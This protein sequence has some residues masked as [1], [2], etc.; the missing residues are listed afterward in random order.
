LQLRAK[1]FGA[2]SWVRL[3][4]FSQMSHP[5]ENRPPKSRIGPQ[6]PLRRSAEAGRS[7]TFRDLSPKRR[8]SIHL[9][10]NRHHSARSACA[11]DARVRVEF[12]QNHRI[13]SEKRAKKIFAETDF[14]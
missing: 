7:G 12:S 6:I 3:G 1:V 14:S 9:P 13:S 11:F 8:A 10:K 2:F 4:S 5:I